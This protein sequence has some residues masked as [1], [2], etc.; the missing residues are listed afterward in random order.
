VQTFATAADRST[1]FPAP[2]KG[3]VSWLDTPGRLE[4]FDGT[5]WQSIPPVNPAGAWIGANPPAGTTMKRFSGWGFVAVNVFGAIQINVPAGWG[6]ITYAS[7]TSGDTS[8]NFAFAQLIVS[9]STLTSIGAYCFTPGGTLVA[10]G[11]TIRVMYL[12]EGW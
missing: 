12:I 3:A 11:T 7:I 4:V 2:K 10:N 8:G 1:Q 9:S 5:A 6:G